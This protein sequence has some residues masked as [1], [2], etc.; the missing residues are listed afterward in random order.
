MTST[1]V[2]GS[3]LLTLVVAALAGWAAARWRLPGGAIIWALSASAALHLAVPA[4]LPL[5]GAFRVAAQ[6]LI[7]ITIGSTIT[8]SP[9]RV[10]YAVRWAVAV[11]VA[12][13]LAASVAAGLALARLTP[14]GPATAV[15][16]LA[17]G[18]A[19]D[20]AV[21]SASF[22]LDAAL[23]AGIQVVRQLLVFVVV[24]LVLSMVP[25]TTESEEP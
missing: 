23:V 15:L 25:A 16:G 4:L 5:P 22:G 9:L 1:V 13:L 18:G 10:L 2:V 21:V 6:I 7:G 19:G 3:V 8:R 24:P 12:L 17:P 20:M 14:L 11:S